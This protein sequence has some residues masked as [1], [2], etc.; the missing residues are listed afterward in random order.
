MLRLGAVILDRLLEGA[1][2]IDRL[3]EH[4]YNGYPAHIF[5]AGLAH[6]VLRRLIF[7]HQAG[8]F[9]AHHRGHRKNGN[10]RGKQAGRTHTPVEDEHQHKHCKDHG[11]A[12]DDVREVV[13]KKRFG[14]RGGAV[15]AVSDEARSVGIKVPQRRFHQM[16]HARFADARGCAEGCKMRAHQSGKI[17][18]DPAEGERERHPPEAG[19]PGRLRPVRRGSDQIPRRKPD[20]DVGDHPEDHGD[21]RKPQTQK[22]QSPVTACIGKQDAQIA[23]FLF[24]HGCF[25]FLG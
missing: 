16:R 15:E 17:D 10:N 18:K 25:S 11:D 2:G 22:G 5:G 6:H 9:A 1:E 13:R 4:L 14:F 24:F 23:F 20:A 3:L 19:D 21:R 12:S 8:I 7:R